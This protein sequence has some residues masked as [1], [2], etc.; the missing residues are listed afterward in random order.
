MQKLQESEIKLSQI[1]KQK[2]NEII[3]L[4]HSLKNESN[5]KNENN[6]KDEKNEKKENHGNYEKYGKNENVEKE[7]EPILIPTEKRPATGLTF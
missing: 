3:L 4:S 6:E 1:I 2:E 7:I 5:K